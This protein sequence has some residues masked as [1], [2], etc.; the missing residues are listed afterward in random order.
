MAKFGDDGR[1]QNGGFVRRKSV[2]EADVVDRVQ[3]F[4]QM[5]RRTDGEGSPGEGVH[6]RVPSLERSGRVVLDVEIGVRSFPV[7]RGGEIWMDIHCI[8]NRPFLTE[9][10]SRIEISNQEKRNLNQRCF[11]R[12]FAFPSF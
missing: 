5:L 4:F 10:V 6:N 2:A 9:K 3:L 12:L 7:D 11:A 8:S 1:H